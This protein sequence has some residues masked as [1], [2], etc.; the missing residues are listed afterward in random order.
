MPGI[1]SGDLLHLKDV[2]DPTTVSH[3]QKP[4]SHKFSQ[5]ANVSQLGEQM[6]GL[7]S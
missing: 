2:L 7:E 4:G 1:E 6:P 3:E 5:I